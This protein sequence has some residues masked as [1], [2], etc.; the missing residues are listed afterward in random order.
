MLHW[1]VTAVVSKFS[2]GAMPKDRLRL[3]KP[4]PKGE[5]TMVAPSRIVQVTMATIGRP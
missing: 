4:Q 1:S 2:Q 5:A 3:S